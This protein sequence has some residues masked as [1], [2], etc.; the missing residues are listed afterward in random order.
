MMRFRFE[1]G[2]PLKAFAARRRGRPRKSQDVGPDRGTPEQ[3]VRRAALVGDAKSELASYPLGVLLA[4]QIISQD[5]HNAGC[6]YARL[7]R[8]VIGRTSSG[9][10]GGSEATDEDVERA[11]SQFDVLRKALVAAGRRQQDAVVNVAVFER[12]PG[13]LVRARTGV[14]RPSDGREAEAL[15]MG[16]TAL[17]NAFGRRRYLA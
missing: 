5:Q 4:R 7:Y 2:D 16:L 10:T 3:Q 11:Q 12:L 1:E 17:L 6:D 8:L 13:W 15:L 9:S 14:V